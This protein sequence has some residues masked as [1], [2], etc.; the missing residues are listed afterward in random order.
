MKRCAIYAWQEY[1]KRVQP[2][3][4]VPADSRHNENAVELRSSKIP[5]DEEQLSKLRI[6]NRFRFKLRLRFAR[7]G[8]FEAK[9]FREPTCP[10]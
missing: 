8:E 2:N 7:I 3:N 10:S 9:I 1:S 6:W 5:P 4:R